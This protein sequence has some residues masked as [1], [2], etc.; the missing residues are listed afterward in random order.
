LKIYVAVTDNT[1]FANLRTIPE[2]DEVNFWQ[3]GGKSRFRAISEGELFLFKLHSP[4]DF[5]AGGG[6][7]FYSNILPVSLAWQAFEEKNG[8][9]SL[10]EMRKL[11]ENLKKEAYTN[12][13]GLWLRI[14]EDLEKPTRR[15]RVED[16]SKKNK[17]YFDIWDVHPSFKDI[18]NTTSLIKTISLLILTFSIIFFSYLTNYNFIYSIVIGLVFSG[19]LIII[20]HNEFFL[21]RKIFPSLFSHKLTFNPFKQ[22]VFW[23]DKNDQSI[24]YCTNRNDL[25]NI[26]LQIFRV[27]VI[28]K[29]VH[30]KIEYF[31]RALSSE[32]IRI[33]F[34]YQIV[35]KPKID[36]FGKQ[37]TRFSSLRS[38]NSYTTSI[39]FSVFYQINGILTDRNLD[40]LR[41]YIKKFSTILKS[42]FIATFHHFK[43][44]LLSDTH[45]INAV[46]TFFLKTEVP[47][48]TG[49]VDKRIML[50][51][52]RINV[53]ARFMF[54]VIIM[55][56]FSF[57]FFK[58]QVP[59][60][61]IIAINFGI[62]FCLLIIWWRSIFFQIS[63]TKLIRADNF[64]VVNPF[65]GIQ[66]YRLREFP[67]SLFLHIDN[68]VLLGMKMVNLKYIKKRPYIY[69]EG[70]FEDLILHLGFWA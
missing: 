18:N 51:G 67:Y 21:L 42:N 49:V 46:R 59:F 47:E 50:N 31:I 33:P 24:L 29:N 30:P 58:L 36:I 13:V 44:T 22:F 39:Y 32:E 38:T 40:K 34:S 43:I 45:L 5:I 25:S 27:E 2:I 57:H 12:K 3:P 56:Y 41:H 16:K 28:P 68:Q 70:F 69:M 35:Q 9:V 15:K 65:E 14:A 37:T 6:V 48:G 26:A 54:C 66:F 64:A 53:F 62:A 1:W 63:K 4:H 61:F 8:A 60:L 23:Y 19:I 10:L 52:N 17:Q 11:I 55:I 20:F 7:F